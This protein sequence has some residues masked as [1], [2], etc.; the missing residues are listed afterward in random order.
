MRLLEEE[1]FF[2]L[3]QQS[4]KKR[5]FFHTYELPVRHEEDNWLLFLYNHMV[6]F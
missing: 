6:V 3:I 2:N 1:Y 4:R 5:N